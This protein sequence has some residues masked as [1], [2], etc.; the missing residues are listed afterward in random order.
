MEKHIK[1]IKKVRKKFDEHLKETLKVAF[2]WCSAI[3]WQ[4][5]INDTIKSFVSVE[6]AWQYE[7]AVALVVTLAGAVAA[8]VI[9]MVMDNV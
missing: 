4:A 5:A 8:F 9:P 6:G 7:I 1:N 3:F 2:I